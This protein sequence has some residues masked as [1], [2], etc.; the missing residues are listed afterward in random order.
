MNV[1]NPRKALEMQNPGQIPGS[2]SDNTNIVT[3]NLNVQLGVRKQFGIPVP[4]KL[5][6]RR[7]VTITYLCFMDLNGN[8]LKDKA[9]P[10]LENIVIRTGDEELMTDLNGQAELIN[11]EAGR[12]KVSL[13]NLS[14]AKTWF[15]VIG[16]SILT[17]RSK[18]IMIPF[19]RGSKI[20]GQIYLQ[21]ERYAVD[22]E[23]SLD[24]SRIVVT[25]TDSMGNKY[26]TI[27]RMDGTFELYIPNARYTLNL[28]AGVWG[29]QFSIVN[30]NMVLDLSQRSD[31]TFVSFQVIERQR[32]VQIKKF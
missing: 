11:L 19:V 14:E 12:Y 18:T 4:A 15:P 28:D 1:S 5:T 21:R 10:E 20:T 30:N 9:E 3:T 27:T 16:D 31:N 2:S 13:I 8:R 23:I 17:D 32:K 26:R 29:D 24:L 7:F 6:H 22:E 25:A